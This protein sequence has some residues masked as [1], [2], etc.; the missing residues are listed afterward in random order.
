MWSLLSRVRKGKISPR[1]TILRQSRAWVATKK[2]T[3]LARSLDSPCRSEL[4]ALADHQIQQPVRH[5]DPLPHLLPLRKPP[6]RRI[7]QRRRHHRLLIRI[8][9]HRAPSTASSRS[10]APRSRP[11]PPPP[12]PRPT[13]ATAPRTPTS[14]CPSRSQLSSA[15]CGANGASMTTSSSAIARCV[16]RCPPAAR[17]PAPSAPRSQVL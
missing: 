9:R 11:G 1:T 4:C 14:V 16:Q 10:P 13:P 3:L 5:V 15:K 12:A 17:S 7:P 8:P 2:G 6:H